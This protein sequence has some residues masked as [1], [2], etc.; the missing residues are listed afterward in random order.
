LIIIFEQ[1]AK[2]EMLGFVPAVALIKQRERDGWSLSALARMIS[3]TPELRDAYDALLSGIRLSA[4]FDPGK[5]ILVTSAQPNEGKTTVASSLAIT[6]S[7][8]GQSV[9]LIDGD[10]RRPW[11][12]SA[13][14]IADGIGLGELLDGQA[15]AGDAIHPFELFENSQEAGSLSIMAAGRKS[16]AFLP[17][18]D[19]SKARTAFRLFSQRFGIVLLDSPPILAVNDALLLGGI[20]DGILLVVDAG[21]ADRDAVRRA[22]EQLEPIRTPIIGAVLNQFDPK[23]HGRPNQPYRGYYLGSPR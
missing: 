9:L 20:V 13:A 7:F 23:I 16:P 2:H 15:E 11:L 19:W 14:G 5:S 10:M 4:A 18:V 3:K 21:S 1:L 22:K 17:A 12:A 8:A 6:A